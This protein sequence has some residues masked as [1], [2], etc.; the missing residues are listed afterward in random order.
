MAKFFLSDDT[1]R[2]HFSRSR[3]VRRTTDVTFVLKHRKYIVI[4]IT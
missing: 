4:R 3:N 2:R 1:V